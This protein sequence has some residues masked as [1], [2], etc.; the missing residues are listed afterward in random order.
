MP[1]ALN[2]FQR[3]FRFFAARPLKLEES[4]HTY[5]AQIYPAIKRIALCGEVSEISYSNTD[6]HY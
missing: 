5:S 1:N 2:A 3:N 4:R 6:Y